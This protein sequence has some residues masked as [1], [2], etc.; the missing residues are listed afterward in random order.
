MSIRIQTEVWKLKMEPS[1]Q[2]VLHCLADWADDV[3]EGVY[4][5]M[6]YVAWKTNYSKRQVQRIVRSLEE[7]GILVCVKPG[8]QHRAREYLIEL[9]S[10]T[11][12]EPFRK[13]GTQSRD[14]KM[15]PLPESRGVIEGSRGDICD[16]RGDMGVTLSVSTNRQYDSLDKTEQAN[17]Q[18]NQ[19]KDG[20]EEKNNPL[21]VAT[22]FDEPEVNT[23]GGGGDL[24]P[25]ISDDLA[26]TVG[27]I[28]PPDRKGGNGCPHGEWFCEG[29]LP[30]STRFCVRCDRD[31][32]AARV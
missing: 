5:S 32:R 19:S 23:G 31:R 26:R 20:T 24:V 25:A 2:H 6:A 4:P 11:Y 12:K 7:Q 22:G 21:P 18:N 15:S 28:V 3:G 1:E 8:G 9:E 30:S 16:T 27:N 10:A 17:N 29:P 14:D 13:P